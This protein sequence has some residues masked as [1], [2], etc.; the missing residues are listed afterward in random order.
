M[1]TPRPSAA[2]AM[3][4]RLAHKSFTSFTNKTSSV[5]RPGLYHAQRIEFVGQHEQGTKEQ[6][7]ASTHPRTKRTR[8]PS[9]VRRR[10]TAAKVIPF[11]G[12]HRSKKPIW[13]RSASYRMGNLVGR[14]MRLE[15]D[16]ISFH[17]AQRLV[18]HCN[19]AEFAAGFH[20]GISFN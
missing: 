11:R 1:P 18:L 13:A 16:N 3:R 5:I 12:L 8:R 7:M 19:E 4:F 10:V 2:A 6:N 14:Y 17:L 9:G 20:D 15:H